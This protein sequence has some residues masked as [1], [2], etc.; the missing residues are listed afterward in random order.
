V[1][2]GNRLVRLAARRRRSSS[3]LALLVLAF[4]G[5]TS[6]V[7]AQGA[8]RNRMA[9]GDSVRIRL[10]GRMMVAAEFREWDVNGIVLDMDGL[11]EPYPVAVS[12]ME[13]LDA[14]MRRTNRESFRHGAVLGAASGIF[15]G[16][17]VG[18]LLHKTGVIS[19]PDDPPAEIFTDTLRWVGLGLIGGAVA[20]GFYFG[21]H[22]GHGWIRIALPVS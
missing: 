8:D 21:S 4:L 16:A 12:D 17:A 20:G 14:F 13:R 2:G 1:S 7:A 19:D 22:P 5:V 11:I 18:L 6:G 3:T 9:S 15:I 10:T